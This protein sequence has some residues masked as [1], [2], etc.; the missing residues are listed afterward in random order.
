VWLAT[1]EG[2]LWHF[3]GAAPELVD[4]GAGLATS[5]ITGLFV[6]R[7]GANR[8]VLLV[9]DRSQGTFRMPIFE[10][11]SRPVADLQRFPVQRRA[12]TWAADGR[13]FWLEGVEPVA[14]H[15]WTGKAME[16]RRPPA[17]LRDAFASASTIIADAE[18][19][20]VVPLSGR[21]FSDQGP[22]VARFGKSGW[23]I[24]VNAPTALSAGIERATP[25]HGLDADALIAVTKD[26]ARCMKDP[27]SN[28]T[29]AQRDG[30]RRTWTPTEVSGAPS[31]SFWAAPGV[32][33]AGQLRVTVNR[34][35][36]NTVWT[37]NG[38][39]WTASEDSSLPPLPSAVSCKGA[40]VVIQGVDGRAWYPTRE[41]LM[42]ARNGVC[43]LR[44]ADLSVDRVTLARFDA[45][46]H[47]VLVRDEEVIVLLDADRF[48]ETTLGTPKQD[49]DRLSLEV[50]GAPVAEVKVDGADWKGF[51]L[52][53]SMLELNGLAKGTHHLEVR[54]ADDQL[55]VDST[56]ASLDVVVR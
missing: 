21:G 22:A 44:R 48:P 33:A 34:L 9:T 28:L 37:W 39:Q 36:R 6:S 50:K 43:R 56:P 53:N 31:S 3:G 4:W 45:K 7:V 32:N 35:G 14:L 29:C 17:P 54:A 10:T 13:L 25:F 12:L 2:P 16:L 55:R 15:E 1:R 30:K 19:V 42:V 46:H 27:N 26:G 38:S 49:G 40:P 52:K 20:W 24:H 23:T 47:D 18:D 5:D 41:G 51:E 8:A 11:V